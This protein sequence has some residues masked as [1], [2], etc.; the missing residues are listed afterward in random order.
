METRNV[1]LY[2][3]IAGVVLLLVGLLAWVGQDQ[4]DGMAL[5]GWIALGLG[6][7]SLAFGL[8]ES[9]SGLRGGMRRRSTRIALQVGM[10]IALVV[11]IIVVV[12][13]VSIKHYKR[14][15]LTPG[16]FFS[17]S[18]KTLRILEKLDKEKRRVEIISFT[19]KTERAAIKS[20][21][22]QYTRRTEMIKF[23][24]VD[25]DASPRTAKKYD[26]DAYGTIVVVHHLGESEKKSIAA[27]AKAGEKEGEKKEGEKKK[28]FRSEK[29]FDLSENSIAN[30]ILKTIQSEQKR[31]YFLTGHGERLHIGR[32][33]ELLSELATGMR[34]DNYKVDELLL[35]RKKRVPKDTKILIIA[36]PKKDIEEAEAGFIEDF[37][38]RGG[39]LLV[40]LEPDTPEG[41][42]TALLKKFGVEAPASASFV[43]DPQAVQFALAGGNQLT[44]FV[45][46]YGIHEITKQMRGM[47][48]MFPTVRRVSA[49]SNPKAGISVEVLA[50]TGKGSFT[51]AGIELKDD[52][53]SYDPKTKK[54]GPV[55]LGAA[56]TV[57]LKAYLKGSGLGGPGGEKAEKQSGESG[58]KEARIVVFGDADFA[59]DAFIGSQG[60][61]N[62]AFNAVNWL[63]GEKALV[64]IRPKSRLGDP[65]ILAG[66]QSTFVLLF[67]LVFMPLFIILAGAAVYVRRR[68]L[69]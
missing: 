28:T 52:K 63:G 24:F 67:T 16:K 2:C 1:N 44:P 3:I 27:K 40:L 18:P 30:A 58:A 46:Q 12:E 38:E 22:E 11:G 66:R 19:R 36:A 32:G 9:R 69:R 41:R 47:A 15:D 29:F 4:F 48:T 64:T 14:W 62:L 5:W 35:L 39:R 65:L 26:V 17:L 10:M 25:L 49:T 23:R 6:A 50:K 51:V 57:N 37:L 31:V 42:L 59:S 7:L 43:I 34:N 33:R 56:I 55:P 8:W 61:A 60:N 54:D 13:L 53:A 21:L 45:L 20:V 68:Q